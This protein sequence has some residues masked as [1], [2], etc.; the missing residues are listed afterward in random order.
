MTNGSIWI[1]KEFIDYYSDSSKKGL[2]LRFYSGVDPFVK[3][4]C[5]KFCNWL[6]SQFWFPLRCG[7][8]FFPWAYFYDQTDIRKKHSGYFYYSSDEKNEKPPIIWLATGEYNNCEAQK[9]QDKLYNIL[10]TL[11][12]ELTHYFQWYF[13]EFNKRTD[14]SLDME[15]NKWGNYLL[16][17]YKTY[18]DINIG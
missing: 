6:R 13:Y 15:A 2:R 3:E 16:Y 10:F 18:R 11:T 1:N 14:R 4:E 8:K 12:H 7:I 5:K 17:E 9:K